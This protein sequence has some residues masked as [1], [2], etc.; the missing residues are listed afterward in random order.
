MGQDGALFSARRV[1]R[2]AVTHVTHLTVYVLKQVVRGYK[3]KGLIRMYVE[4]VVLS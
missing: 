2:D 1:S 3:L 4:S